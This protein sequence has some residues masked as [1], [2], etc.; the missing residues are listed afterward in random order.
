MRIKKPRVP[1]QSYAESGIYIYDIRLMEIARAV[2]S[3]TLGEVR[4]TDV[5]LEHMRRGKPK[6]SNFCRVF[7]RLDAG[8][9]P[10]LYEAYAQIEPLSVDICECSNYLRI[11]VGDWHQLKGEKQ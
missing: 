10:A 11:V 2:R 9:G 7:A 3:S 8:S 5:N 1:K 6:G 4:I